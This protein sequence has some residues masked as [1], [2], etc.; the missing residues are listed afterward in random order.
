MGFF[1]YLVVLLCLW[2]TVLLLQAVGLWGLTKHILHLLLMIFYGFLFAWVLEPWIMRY[3]IG[4]RVIRVVF[5]YLMFGLFCGLILW[6]CIPR[7][8]LLWKDITMEFPNWMM[9]VKQ[10]IPETIWNQGYQLMV[11]KTVGFMDGMGNVGMIF[12]SAFFIS[13]DMEHLKRL[14]HQFFHFSF[15][16]ENFYHTACNIIYQYT[17][18]VGLDL[19]F[20]FLSASVLL[21][22]FQFPNAFVYAILLALFNLFPVIGPL[23]GW[24]FISAIAW[25]SYQQFPMVLI[26]LL[27]LLQQIESNWIQPLIFKK[28]ME[29][30]P[31]LTF[32]SLL[33]CGG[34]FGVMGMIFSPIVAGIVQLMFR[35]FL[36]SKKRK[37]VGTWD[38]VWY[39]FQD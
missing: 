32:I 31:T 24:L 20:L 18:G 1:P 19:L 34:L 25:L 23:V 6:A 3:K 10:Q 37:T 4:T 8:V 7:F 38:E 14:Y 5:V 27:F 30:R 15:L 2:V 11:Q 39:N 33:V 35:S 26:V 29:L 17:K 36:F 16:D 21:W 12:M 22:L 28:V 9:M 13:I